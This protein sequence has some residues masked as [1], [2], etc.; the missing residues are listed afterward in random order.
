MVRRRNRFMDLGVRSDEGPAEHNPVDGSLMQRMR[1]GRC[2]AQP[3]ERIEKSAV[4]KSGSGL[5]PTKIKVKIAC[6]KHR[7]VRAVALSVL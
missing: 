4:S 5:T 7:H 3:R 2:L 1:D 6:R